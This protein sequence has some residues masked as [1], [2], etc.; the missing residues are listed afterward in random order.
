MS[1]KKIGKEKWEGKPKSEP[2]ASL[3]PPEKPAPPPY[4]PAKPSIPPLDFA[5]IDDARRDQ[6]IDAIAFFDGRR[7]VD[8]N[9]RGLL[10][11]ELDE[12]TA[13]ALS[14]FKVEEIYEWE[15]DGDTGRQARVNVGNLKE[16][17]I[18]YRLKA[19]ELRAKLYGRLS[20]ESAKTDK[21]NLLLEYLKAVQ[22]Q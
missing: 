10:M 11:S 22:G 3:L 18:E 19:L 2:D 7:C 6:L 5:A 21:K 20:G 8:E 1:K 9:G 15:P 17:K 16:Y 4:V 13:L 12:W 14:T